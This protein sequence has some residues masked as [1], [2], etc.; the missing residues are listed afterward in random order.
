MFCVTQRTPMASVDSLC[1]L[2]R[3]SR[4]E[5]SPPNMQA[6]R[7]AAELARLSNVEYQSHED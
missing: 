3:N 2:V 1:Y 7:S 6:T 4:P 5:M